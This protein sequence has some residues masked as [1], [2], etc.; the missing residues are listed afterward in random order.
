MGQITE[1]NQEATLN[2]MKTV[3]GMACKEDMQDLLV[4]FLIGKLRH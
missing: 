2:Q 4:C 1:K 3:E